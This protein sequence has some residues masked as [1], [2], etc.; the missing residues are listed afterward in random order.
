MFD[1][2]SICLNQRCT[3]FWRTCE[4]A[5]PELGIAYRPE[6]LRC[7]P[8]AEEE[9]QMPNIPPTQSM[10]RTEGDDGVTTTS[11][12]LSG[13]WC[14]KCG[15]MSSRWVRRLRC[16]ACVA[17]AWWIVGSN[18]NAG[19]AATLNV[20]YVFRCCPF[21]MLMWRSSSRCPYLVVYELRRNSKLYMRKSVKKT[22]LR[23]EAMVSNKYQR[24]RPSID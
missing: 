14:E 15:R 1:S 6:F 13:F 20:A 23:Q 3:R 18:G 11:E 7:V 22:K 24:G 2:P 5:V 8:I 19:S 4:G 16:V 9:G 12:F 10:A 21:C 17:E